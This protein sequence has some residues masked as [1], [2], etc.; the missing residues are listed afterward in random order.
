MI[1]DEAEP[2]FQS[3]LEA[4]RESGGSW[5]RAARLLAQ[6]DGKLGDGNEGT[7]NDAHKDLRDQLPALEE[8]L[9]DLVRSALMQSM[10]Q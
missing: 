10:M 7:K 3:A 2:I 6:S 8:R 5:R 1:K 9:L 4:R